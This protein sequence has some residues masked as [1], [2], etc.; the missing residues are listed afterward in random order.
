LYRT[1]ARHS[2]HKQAVKAG[3]G[4]SARCRGRMR[5]GEREEDQS[6]CYQSSHCC[7]PRA[8]V[9][10]VCR[11]PRER[12]GAPP[13]ALAVVGLHHIAGLLQ[14]HQSSRVQGRA[15]ATGPVQVLLWQGRR[16]A[17]TR[18]LGACR[19][20]L[21]RTGTVGAG[22]AAVGWSLP[23]MPL[24][25]GYSYGRRREALAWISLET[26]T[27]GHGGGVVKGTVGEREVAL[28]L[29]VARTSTGQTWLR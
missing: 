13:R 2:K 8:R 4:S 22:G 15:A 28:S 25:L 12:A 1:I 3:R 11:S 18:S 24:A 19:H 21:A 5:E 27:R 29:P 7:T 9:D 17:R 6:N 26:T 23:V 14:Q 16:P 20:R 10:L